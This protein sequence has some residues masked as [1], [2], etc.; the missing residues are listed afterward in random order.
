MEKTF[1]KK[2]FNK[3][4]IVAHPDD[5]LIFGG[6]ELIQNK[7]Y[8]VVCMTN[9]NNEK[10]LKEFTGLMKEL[11]VAYEILD[12][13]DDS[14]VKNIDDEYINYIETLLKNKNIEKIVTHNKK[15]E[16]GHNFHKSVSKM[17]TDLCDK[18]DLL[19]KL[20]YFHT[21]KTKI[22][23]KLIKRKLELMEKHY[24]SQFRVLVNLKLQK[25]IE[26]ET[27]KKFK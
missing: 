19:D 26:N 5:E 4:M 3:L 23:E 6:A 7:G 17:V 25:S 10:R 13:K 24:P 11:K 8:K 12:H 20:Y 27:L 1:N 22:D 2:K 18:N 9:Q 15:G 16:Y 21:G 14:R